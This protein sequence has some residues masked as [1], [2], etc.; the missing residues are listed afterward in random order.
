MYCKTPSYRGFYQPS[1][2]DIQ[3]IPLG[4]PTRFDRGRLL[5][6]EK[7]QVNLLT[8]ILETWNDLG[9]LGQTEETEKTA[10]SKLEVQQSPFFTLSLAAVG[11][12]VIDKGFDSSSVCVHLRPQ[13][14][15]ALHPPLLPQ[16]S[17]QERKLGRETG[18][19]RHKTFPRKNIR[20]KQES[21]AL[22]G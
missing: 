18:L 8:Q 13:T 12:R 19:G 10:D 14:E 2:Q 17:G 9:R 1:S 6:R 5:R 4:C 22:S 7:P 20:N 3:P 21:L 15:G 16:R 11:D